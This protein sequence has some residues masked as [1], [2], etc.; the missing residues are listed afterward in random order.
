MADTFDVQRER[1]S[2]SLRSAYTSSRCHSERQPRRHP[3]LLP[4]FASPPSDFPVPGGPTTSGEC[5]PAVSWARLARGFGPNP[6]TAQSLRKGFAPAVQVDL[7]RVQPFAVHGFGP[8]AQMQTLL[9]LVQIHHKVMALALH[10][11]ELMGRPQDD[12]CIGSPLYRAHAIKALGCH[13][14]IPQYCQ[15]A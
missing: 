14:H 11:R 6:R 4:N 7:A 10:M 15:R 8:H 9:M 3:A 2:A 5:A 12:L 13:G 1:G